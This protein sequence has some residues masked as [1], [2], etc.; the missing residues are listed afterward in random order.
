M[1]DW[2]RVWS[3][4]GREKGTRGSADDLIPQR[5]C[6]ACSQPYEAFYKACP[7]CGAIPVPAGRSRPEQVDGDL[8]ELDVEGMAALFA[9]MHKADLD[10]DEFRA[11]LFEPDENG[12][13]VPP[14]FHGPAVKR[15]QSAKYRRTVLKELVGWWI[16]MQGTERALDEKHRRFFHRFGIDIGYAFTLDTKDTNALIERIGRD[17]AKDMTA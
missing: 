3:L 12:K 6:M 15:H 11:S 7:H 17:F 1:P 4:L 14:K 2:P 10:D 9:A 8:S 13:I 5:V 16:G